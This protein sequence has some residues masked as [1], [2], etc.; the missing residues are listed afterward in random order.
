MYCLGENRGLNSTQL[1][2]IAMLLMVLDHIYEFFGYTGLVPMWFT[3]LGRLVAPIFMFTL[4][5]GFF[6]TH[7]RKE[8]M[9]RLY[10]GA[11]FMGIFNYLLASIIRRPDDM[12]IL[13]NIFSTFFMIVFYLYFIEKIKE[14]KT[15]GKSIIYPV[16]AIVLSI[17]MCFVPV[18]ISIVCRE[19]GIYLPYGIYAIFMAILP[20]PLFVEGGPVFVVIGMMLYYMRKN[21]IKQC[22]S[23]II[24]SLLLFTGGG[25]NF[26]N[27]FYINYQWMMV[28][29]VLILA[30]YNNQKGHGYK[31][32]FYLFYPIHVY[33]LYILSVFM[34]AN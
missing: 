17:C 10:I 9:M 19:L 8:Y 31:Y 20:A 29:S 25:Y 23:F 27:L 16:I 30:M 22:A 4:A 33:V 12:P 13:N 7:N 21:R 3:F 34:M 15:T 1:K 26:Q 18:F 14:N 28:F 6:Y 11:V 2:I 24:V 32:L 5:E